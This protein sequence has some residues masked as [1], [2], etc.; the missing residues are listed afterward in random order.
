MEDQ[1]NEINDVKPSSLNHLVGQESVKAQVA[2]AIDASFQDGTRFPDSLLVGPPGLGKSALAAVIAEEMASGFHE[3]LA[4]SVVGIA[5]MNALLLSA[6]DKSIVFLDEIH[7]LKPEL[8]TALYLALDK[9]M[10]FLRNG[11]SSNAPQGIPI[12]DFSLALA[13]T[14][15]Y[16]VLAPLRDR[17]KL[18]LRLDYYH[19]LELTVVLTQRS[20]ALGWELHEEILPNIAK[21]SRG[22]PR[23][24]LRLLQACRRV[25]RAE[26]EMI[27]TEVHLKR[28]CLLEQTDELGLGPN[29][30]KYLRLLADGISR[31][32]VVASMLGLPSR[33]VTEV[34][35]PFLLRAQLVLKDD[36]G[37][38]QLT[39][40]GREHV[41]KNRQ[42][43]V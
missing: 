35:E 3:V 29:E 2:V 12:A 20:R 9:R 15:E 4:Q 19:E 36:Q 10:I 42:E 24:A 21:R 28:A 41:V 31:V 37:R 18:L 17:M 43:S 26:G 5:E 1:K 16:R 7:E 39:A 33:T 23:F 6:S 25:C 22:T 27:I 38:R 34:V 30:Q 14:D 11:K 8:Q 32:N 40:A 13:T